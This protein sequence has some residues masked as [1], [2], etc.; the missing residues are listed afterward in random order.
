[1]RLSRS[2]LHGAG[3]TA[4]IRQCTEYAAPIRY[5]DKERRHIGAAIILAQEFD[6]GPWPRFLTGRNFE[7]IA[8]G[9]TLSEMGVLAASCVR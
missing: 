6:L 4:A 2:A 8:I 9:K 3:P 5:D 1:M 7:P